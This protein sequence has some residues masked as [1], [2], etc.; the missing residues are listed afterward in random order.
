MALDLSGFKNQYPEWA[1]L[2]KMADT[3]ETRNLRQQAQSA[4]QANK[5]NAAGTFLQNYLDPKDYMSGTAFDPMIVQGL[6]EA[7]QR[8]SQLAM[9][10]ADTPTLMMALGPMV[11]RLNMYS[12]NAKNINK[13]IDESI[14]G[15]QADKQEGYNWQALKQAALQKAFF[16]T[17][18][19]GNQVLDPEQ[20]N[21]SVDWISK[22]IE[23]DP[24][25]VTTPEAFDL[26][27]KNAQVN[28]TLKD[29]VTMDPFGRRVQTKAHLIAQNYLTPDYNEDKK[30][31]DY[32]TIK[33]FVPYH[34]LAT[35]KGSPLYHTFT[36]DKGTET[37]AQVRLLRED[38]FDSLRPGQ[39]NYIRGQVKKHINE[40]ETATGEKISMDSPKAKLI[41]RA[42]AY[43]E[44]NKPT[45]KATNIEYAH[46]DQLSPQQVT[47]NIQRT[48]EYLQN[49]RDKAAAR[50]QG[51]LDVTGG[52]VNSLQAIG[53]IFN[54]DP[55]YTAGQ[56]IPKYGKQL[57]D[58]TAK[59]PGGGL[60]TGP[61]INFDYKGIYYDPKDRAL[62]VEKESSNPLTGL[63]S[64]ATE[65]ISEKDIGNFMYRI[66]ESNGVPYRQVRK[67]LDEMGYKNN[68]FTKAA[69]NS[70]E[71]E[72]EERA[73]KKSWHNAYI[74]PLSSSQLK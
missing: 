56:K 58:V 18:E 24:E 41:A 15:M 20:A 22:A 46:K 54:N 7:M 60:K 4:Q 61:G 71:L 44:L 37:K 30:S 67:I 47:L 70:A 28:K 13:Q 11:N 48:D 26:Y 62:I 2:Y 17:D 25:K 52:E 51:R 57:L 49:E 65:T 12:T 1:G 23:E 68:K 63:K 14:K 16:K 43:D 19:Q 39:I 55:E 64:I 33:G 29:I 36:D 40:Y 27:A 5:R 6:Q 32:K 21:P 42:L 8:G 59:L 38:I 45:R 3:L 9:A 73:K 34:D 69:D 74:N 10:G 31:K 66:A 50:K 72:F 53:Q 35:E